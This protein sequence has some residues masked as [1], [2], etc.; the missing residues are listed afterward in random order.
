[1]IV[2]AGQWY[3]PILISGSG[4]HRVTGELYGV[5]DDGLAYLDELEGD[6][7]ELGFDRIQREVDLAHS[8]TVAFSY[9]KPRDRIDVIH[10]EPLDEYHPDPRYVPGH[11]RGQPNSGFGSRSPD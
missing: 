3:T 9:A 11:Q 4:D 2:I 1:M 10:G 8:W 7:R 5:D 6:G